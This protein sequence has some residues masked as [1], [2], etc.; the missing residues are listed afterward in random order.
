MTLIATT[1]VSSTANMPTHTR[2]GNCQAPHHLEGILFCISPPLFLPV[3]LSLSYL[4]SSFP[5][6]HGR[7]TYIYFPQ[8]KEA[9][10]EVGFAQDPP[11]FKALKEQEGMKYNL[12][13]SAFNFFVSLSLSSSL[14]PS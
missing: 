10:L 8:F 1:G 2:R 9:N 12:L 3:S 5:S 7:G 4:P 11:A 13:G 6:R 14:I